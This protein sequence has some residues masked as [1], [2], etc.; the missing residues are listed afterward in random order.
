[1][2]MCCL[3]KTIREFEDEKSGSDSEN[4]LAEIIT[5]IIFQ[6]T[7]CDYHKDGGFFTCEIYADYR[8]YADNSTVIKWCEA[9]NPHEA[10]NE[11]LFCWYQ[12]CIFE[13][14]DDVI[15]TVKK[16]WTDAELSFDD[17][18]EFI[19]DWIREHVTIEIPT[20]HYLQQK[21]CVDIIVDTGDGNYDFVSNDMFPHYNARFGDVIPEEASVLW[22]ARQ[23]GYKKRQLNRAMRHCDYS[24]S[25]LLK[26]LRVEV[27]NCSSHMNALAFF[28]EMTVE[29]LFD[30]NEAIKDNGK[31]DPPLNKDEYRCTWER[32]GKRKI[33]LD[34]SAVCGLYDSWSG[35]GSILEIELE[36]DV[37]LPMKYISTALP[38]GGRGYSVASIYGVCSSMWTP[39]LKK[40][41]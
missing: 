9:D 23:Q 4:R 34:K 39:S 35:A 13:C 26:S 21:V 33:T 7:S 8:D 40:I 14:E 28:V 22:L 29:Q 32:K 31:N 15:D 27:H 1:M 41:A 11:E 6:H 5:D 38:D 17:N 10:F 2:K 24:G 3:E 36:K 16:H 25:E 19:V 37:V 20:N 30:L 18:E 12:D